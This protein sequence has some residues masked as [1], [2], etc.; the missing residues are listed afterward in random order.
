MYTAPLWIPP[1]ICG[2]NDLTI[3][4]STGTMGP[5]GPP[6]PQGLQGPKGDQ[7][8]KG[9]TGE[10]GDAGAQGEPGPEG[11]PGPKGDPG[12]PGPGG[13]CTVAT[14]VTRTSY[15]CTTDHCYIGV[16][17]KKPTTINLP[18]NPPNGKIVIV[19]AEMKPPLG[20]RKITI[21][22]T[23]GSTIDFDTEATIEVSLE[24]K[25]FIYHDGEWFTI[26]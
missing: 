3:L 8:E 23:D 13:G 17:S 6:G 1:I 16:D 15:D 21:T 12:P 19:K 10:K 11:P 14:V 7:G 25:T 5:P 26:Y 18:A 2:D 20:N 9:Q 22:T 4:A 24:S